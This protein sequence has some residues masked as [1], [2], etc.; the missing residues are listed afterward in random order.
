MEN[1]PLMSLF[2]TL[3]ISVY[4]NISC[5]CQNWNQ[6]TEYQ[7]VVKLSGTGDNPNHRLATIEND[8]GNQGMCEKIKH[9]TQTVLVQLHIEEPQKKN[10]LGTVN[11]S[12]HL[13][14]LIL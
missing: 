4:I 14:C 12:I 6:D 8:S 11:I 7:S 1:C 9:K 5:R 10:L 2:E 13:T 3:G